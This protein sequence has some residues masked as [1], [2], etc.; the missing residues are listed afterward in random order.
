MI[1][2][3]EKMTG[4]LEVNLKEDSALEDFFLSS[5]FCVSGPPNKKTNHMAT[6]FQ[7]IINREIPAEV[8]FEDDTC[9]SIKDIEPQAPF[10]ALIIPKN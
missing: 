7:K 6:I 9:I 4:L 3:L 8:I 10:H 2:K 5:F 1:N